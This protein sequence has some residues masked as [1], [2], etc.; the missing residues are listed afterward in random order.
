MTWCR[1]EKTNDQK[2]CNYYWD[3][4]SAL[5]ISGGIQLRV[6]F[7]PQVKWMEENKEGYNRSIIIIML[8]IVSLVLFETLQFSLKLYAGTTLRKE[9]KESG[10]ILPYR[11][12]L[13]YHFASFKLFADKNLCTAVWLIP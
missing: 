12:Y 1:G 10:P 2:N 7:H 9:N 6:N 11:H 8:P 5:R 3:L 13:A 4:I